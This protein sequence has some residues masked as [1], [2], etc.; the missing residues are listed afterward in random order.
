M[1]VREWLW[2]VGDFRVGVCQVSVSDCGLLVIF[3]LGFFR[4]GDWSFGPKCGWWLFMC[5]LRISCVHHLL[6]Q[7]FW[8]ICWLNSCRYGICLSFRLEGRWGRLGYKGARLQDVGVYQ[9]KGWQ[10]AKHGYDT[11]RWK[12]MQNFG[13]QLQ[14]QLIF[15]IICARLYISYRRSEG[16]RMDWKLFFP[17]A[18]PLF[19]Y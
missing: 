1:C 11:G 8:A 6:S 14:C 19:F 12:G 4:H 2:F 7:R 15:K 18:S 13:P 5:F 10:F 17:N 16:G 9:Y 3:V